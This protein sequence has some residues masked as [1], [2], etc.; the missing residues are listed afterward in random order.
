MKAKKY[1]TKFIRERKC[2]CV[3]NSAKEIIN[4]T[5]TKS[6]KIMMIT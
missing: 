2:L 1:K 5:E 3:I 6:T 4:T